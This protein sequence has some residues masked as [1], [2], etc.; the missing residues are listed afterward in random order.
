MASREEPTETS[1]PPP[2][3]TRVARRMYALIGTAARALFDLNTRAGNEP[4]YSLDELRSWSSALSL[5]DELEP[6]ESALLAQQQGEPAQRT[7][8][9]ALWGIE[10]GCVLSWALGVTP[11]PAYDA[12]VD[13]DPL[14]AAVKLL[15]DAE[16]I[17][18]VERARLRPATELER[19]RQQMLAYHWRMVD[20]RIA[21][22]PVRLDE[23]RIFGPFDLSWARLHD[24]DL[25]LAGEPLIDAD[26]G[27]TQT[28]RSISFER[29]R[30]AN[31]LCG[32]DSTFSKTPT[33]T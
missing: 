13:V 12:T 2:T 1:G 16:S 17:N 31:W 14:F 27:V 30:A 22:R 7:L 5:A 24:G 28:C 9:N 25:T 32:S 6:H 23:V 15:N 8:I 3:A 19:F 33:D 29:F 10:G 11:L 4:A 20:F 26:E 18:L 21:P